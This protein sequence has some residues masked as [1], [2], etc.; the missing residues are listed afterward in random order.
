VRVDHRRRDVRVP[1]QFLH[2]S[3]VVAILEQLCRKRVPVMP[4]AA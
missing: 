4:R 1:E 2:G 3:D